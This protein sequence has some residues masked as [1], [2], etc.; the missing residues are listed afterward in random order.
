[1]NENDPN[2]IE[3]INSGVHKYLCR[4]SLFSSEKIYG[5]HDGMW[6]GGKSK[7]RC[8]KRRSNKRKKY[9]RRR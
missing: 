1:M 3:F 6:A 4:P 9:S 8:T 5:T 7:R 2:N